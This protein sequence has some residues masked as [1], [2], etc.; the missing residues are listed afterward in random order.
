MAVGGV[1][2]RPIEHDVELLALAAQVLLDLRGSALRVDG[3]AAVARRR[4]RA[5]HRHREDARDEARWPSPRRRSSRPGCRW[6][7]P[8]RRSGFRLRAVTSRGTRELVLRRFHDVLQ[9]DSQV[10][11][12][13][14]LE[15]ADSLPGDAE[16]ALDRLERLLLPVEAEA[17]L[18]DPALELGKRLRAPCELPADATRLAASSTGST[19]S[20]SAKR[21][22]SSP[23][24]SSPTDWF[25]D[26]DAS[27]APS[28]SSTCWTS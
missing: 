1:D 18:E 20:R 24:P 16:L 4:R 2:A 15:P 26:T 21:S 28:A 23:P 9:L 3:G 22:P 8:R 12:G 6:T 11:K 13:V 25:S 17:Q 19:A 27:T 5:G 7:S 10:G 14:L